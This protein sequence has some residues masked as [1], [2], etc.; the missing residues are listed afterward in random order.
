MSGRTLIVELLTEELPPKALP[1][2]SAAFAD[3]IVNGLRTRGFL[4]AGSTVER[5]A[6]PRRLA[7]KI[8]DVSAMSPDE[9]TREKLVPASVG[10]DAAGKP[11]VAFRKAAAKR[12]REALVDAWPNSNDGPDR[13]VIESDGKADAIFFYTV[14]KGSALTTGLQSALADTIAALPIPKVM[15]YQRPDG[16][17]Q[18]FVRPAHR[19]LALHGTDVVQVS[20][21]GLDAGRDTE[22]HRFQGT[23]AITLDDASEYP[24]RLQTEGRVIASFDERRS[25]IEAALQAKASSLGAALQPDDAYAALLDEVTALTENPAIYAG[26]FDAEFLDVPQECLILT[27]RTNQKYFPLFDA[28]GKL[29]RDFLIVSNMQLADPSRVIQG[30][31]RVVRPRLAD[32]KFFFDQDRRTKLAD[33]V[34]KLG[35]VVY[36]NKLGTQLQR[37]ER[38]QKLANRIAAAIGA[39]AGLAQHAAALAK[40]DLVTDMVGEFPELQGI[41]GRYYALHDGEPAEVADAIEQHYRPK[42]AGDALPETPVAVAVALADKLDTLVGIYG[43][44]LIPTGDKDAFG[45]RRHAVGVLRILI[46]RKL[47]V[48][49]TSLLAMAAERFPPGVLSPKVVNDLHGFML[50]R[51]RGMLREQGYSAN[52]VEAVLSQMPTRIDLVPARLAAVRE[53]GTLPEAAALASANKRIQNILRKSDA[54]SGTGAAS[55]TASDAAAGTPAGAPGGAPTIAASNAVIDPALIAE[56]AEKKLN[57]ALVAAEPGVGAHLA[58]GRYTPALKALAALRGDVDAFFDQ[59]MVNA[60][61]PRLRA[62]RHALLRRLGALMNQVADISKLAA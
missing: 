45:L 41:M 36:H 5:Y 60:D 16:S 11:T 46:E 1:R 24:R 57:A 54:E 10:L 19:L 51:L 8:G 25:A 12:G 47:P 27:M 9:S 26:T 35:S 59:V 61:D 3:G 29:R 15:T 21:L 7:V 17:D 14:A 50:E 34:A 6:T 28:S 52:E 58:A 55:V 33:R 20:A 30:N 48:E 40:A 38:M 49:L 23:R 43:I 22:G 53:F 32:A 2:L 18:K 62:N 44:G 13:F 37:V 4:D 56:G 31:E 42:F 39:D